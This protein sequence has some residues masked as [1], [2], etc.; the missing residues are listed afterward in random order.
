ML[1][2]ALSILIRDPLG[3]GKDEENVI[4]YILCW[5]P[6]IDLDIVT[7]TSHP[8]YMSKPKSFGLVVVAM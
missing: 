5:L 2:G 7:E 1:F 4:L 8:V 3:Y 6:S